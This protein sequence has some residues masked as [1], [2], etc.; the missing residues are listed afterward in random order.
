MSSPVVFEIFLFLLKEQQEQLETLLEQNPETAPKCQ[1]NIQQQKKGGQPSMV[2]QSPEIVKHVSITKEFI[3]Q[4]GFAA[5]CRRRTNTGNSLGVTA[6]QILYNDIPGLKE[7]S[8]SLFIIL[9]LF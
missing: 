3:K 6:A 7:H 5:Q 1:T 8:V 9:T 2:F 4:H